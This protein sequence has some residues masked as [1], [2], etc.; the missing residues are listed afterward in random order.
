MKQRVLAKDGKNFD[1]HVWF[2]DTACNKA[3][4][5]S[6]GMAEHIERYDSFA[7]ACNKQGIAVFG[8]NHRGHGP[9]AERLGHF[10]DINGWQLVLDDLD[11]VIDF[12]NEEYEVKP[13]LLGHSMGSFA[14]RHYAVQNGTKLSALVLCGSNH[15]GVLM[16]RL[17]LIAAKLVKVFTGG[18][19]PS[20]FLEKLSFG[21]YN[22][23]IKPLRTEQ[24]WLCRDESIVDAYIADPYCGFTPTPQFWID[25]LQGLTDMSSAEAFARIPADLPIMIISGDS[26]P[27]NNYG[28]GITALENALREGGV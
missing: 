10:A 21:N 20:P 16:F 3:I 17:G 28:K 7:K 18:S 1:L 24:D 26:D 11:S 23:K 8:A 22:S 15:Q 12:V 25:L 9:N 27:V 2:P 14:A 4:I 6:H 19:T 5:L 13:V